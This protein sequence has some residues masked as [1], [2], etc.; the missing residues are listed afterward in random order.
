MTRNALPMIVMA[1]PVLI[2]VL[3]QGTAAAISQIFLA[4]SLGIYLVE[5]VVVA[6]A[7][8]VAQTFGI[9]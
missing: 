6:V 3:E 1:M 5:V 2:R 4:M 9:P 8:I 7:A